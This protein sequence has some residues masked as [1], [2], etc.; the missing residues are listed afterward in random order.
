[1]A[2]DGPALSPDRHQI[3]DVGPDGRYWIY[4]VDGGAGRPVN[5]LS[6]HDRIVGWREDS[7]NIFISTHHDV[8]QSIPVSVL[9]P[10]SGEKTPWKELRTARAVDSLSNLV[11]TPDG[12]AWAANFRVKL[13]DLY[14][15][16]GLK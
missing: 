8:N 12:R 9:D 10:A 5:G 14:V 2:D 6:P 1:V 16:S 7:R 11:I 4:P 3:L 15:A 13:S